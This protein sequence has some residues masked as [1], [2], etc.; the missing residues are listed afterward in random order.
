MSGTECIRLMLAQ[1]KIPHDTAEDFLN[2]APSKA[3]VSRCRPLHDADHAICA[4]LACGGQPQV[5]V[6]QS[7]SQSVMACGLLAYADV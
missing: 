3:V 1:E 6:S 2:S 5:L 4:L 7:V